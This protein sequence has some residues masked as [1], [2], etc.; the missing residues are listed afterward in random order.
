VGREIDEN[1]AIRRL[2]VPRQS[3]SAQ[4]H[5]RRSCLP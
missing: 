3:F 4:L 5:V 1:W 2:S